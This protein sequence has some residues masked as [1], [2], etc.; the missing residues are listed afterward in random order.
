MDDLFDQSE[1]MVGALA[2]SD[3]RDIRSFPRGDGSHFLDIDLASD[4]LM[5][6]G[7]NHRRYQRQA[8][9]GAA[10]ARLISPRPL[11]LQQSF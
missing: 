2:Q 7:G 10:S 4:H 11:R 9:L 6:K 1:R 5:A 8:I 3:Q